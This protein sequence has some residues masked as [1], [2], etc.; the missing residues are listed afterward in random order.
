MPLSSDP[1]REQILDQLTS[2]RPIECRKKA[3]GVALYKN[4]KF[5]GFIFGGE[6]YFKVSDLT[7]N[8]FV[9]RNMQPFESTGPEKIVSFYGV[10]LTVQK[11]S[12]L[13][14]DWAW[15]AIRSAMPAGKRRAEK[16]GASST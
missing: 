16:S 10:P 15:D 8:D 14:S 11:N 4:G 6:L 7:R 9:E 3:G 2:L 13:L 12:A 5:F 1:F